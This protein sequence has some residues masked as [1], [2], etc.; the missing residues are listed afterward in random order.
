LESIPHFGSYTKSDISKLSILEIAKK[1]GFNIPQTII[2]TKKEQLICFKK[3]FICKPIYEAP[4]VIDGEYLLRPFTTEV[5]LEL[6]EDEFFPSLFQEK[7]DA[8]CELRIFFF[9]NKYF[10]ASIH[11]E[12]YDETT[13]W[14]Y[15]WAENKKIGLKKFDIPQEMLSNLKKLSTEIGINTGSYDF[16]VDKDGNLFFLE[17]NPCGQFSFLDVV[18]GDEIYEHIAQTLINA[19]NEVCNTHNL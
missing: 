13:D 3:H 10:A 11:C 4:K 12:D 5:K 19:H 6:L 16:I 1:V 2:A 14:R 15:I 9:G 17:V 7:I 18:F 8:L